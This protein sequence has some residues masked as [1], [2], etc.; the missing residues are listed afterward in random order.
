MGQLNLNNFYLHPTNIKSSSLKKTI[1]AS[2]WIQSM[3]KTNV[4]QFVFARMTLNKFTLDVERHGALG[5][6]KRSSSTAARHVITGTHSH[7]SG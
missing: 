6:W 4:S 7:A 3:K 5:Y 2:V 1:A